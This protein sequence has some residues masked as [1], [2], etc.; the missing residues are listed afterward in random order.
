MDS[1]HSTLI[2]D[3]EERGR[4]GSTWLMKYNEDIA[5]LINQH[6]F[7]IQ[8]DRRNGSDFKCYD[9]GT[10]EFRSFIKEQTGFS[11][12][13]RRS[14]TDICTLCRDICGVNLSI[15]YYDEHTNEERINIE[16]WLNTLR[17]TQ[18]LLDNELPR[19]TR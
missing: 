19:F 15:G 8:F 7:M 6:Q 5:N 4:M 16:E 18:K 3:G 2:T 11:E 17:I 13:D 12:P 1:G 9:V 14:Y 10:D